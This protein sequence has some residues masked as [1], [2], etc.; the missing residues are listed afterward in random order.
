M[1]SGSFSKDSSPLGLIKML[2]RQTSSPDTVSRTF[3]EVNPPWA[4]PSCFWKHQEWQPSN[5]SIFPS[6]QAWSTALPTVPGSLADHLQPLVEWDLGSVSAGQDTTG[7]PESGV[8]PSPGRLEQLQVEE[9]R[10]WDGWAQKTYSPRRFL[11]E[12][13]NPLQPWQ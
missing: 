2:Q 4:H 5:K 9:G 13:P 1:P 6:G 12:D 10:E 3:G 8:F 7:S 11:S